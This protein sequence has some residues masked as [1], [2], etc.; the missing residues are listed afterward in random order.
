MNNQLSDIHNDLALMVAL[1]SSK[2]EV[3]Q[4]LTKCFE[5]LIVINTN[6][7]QVAEVWKNS[8]KE[9]RES[10]KI[11]MEG[12]DAFDSEGVIRAFMDNYKLNA[13]WMEKS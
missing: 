5:Q 9:S 7:R 11:M 4:H 12:I 2:L 6:F 3:M 10:I 1:E 8:A 13:L